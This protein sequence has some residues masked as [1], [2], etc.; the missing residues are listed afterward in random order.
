MFNRY[1]HQCAYSRRIYEHFGLSLPR[2]I[3]GDRYRHGGGFTVNINA[4]RHAQRVRRGRQN[5]S[6]SY[7]KRPPL[8]PEYVM[9]RESFCAI[10]SG[11]AS[12]ASA[13]Q[14]DRP[15]TAFNVQ[16]SVVVIGRYGQERQRTFAAW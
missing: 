11:P 3:R 8:I 9:T 15:N 7:N 4:A 12:V 10:V 16:R 5:Y 13:Y 2:N 1:I 14:N 6:M